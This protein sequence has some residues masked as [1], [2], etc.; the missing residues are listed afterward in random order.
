MIE[1]IREA[2]RPERAHPKRAAFSRDG[3]FTF[4][5]S[6]L[7]IFLISIVL[8]FP[9]KESQQLVAAGKSVM[10]GLS[11]GGAFAS[12]ENRIAVLPP[13]RGPKPRCF[14]DFVLRIPSRIHQQMNL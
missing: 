5:L 13:S 8:R 3:A 4:R 1:H 12:F 9:L 7:K 2:R 11:S 10:T 6:P 14:S